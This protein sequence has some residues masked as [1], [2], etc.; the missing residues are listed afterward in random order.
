MVQFLSNWVTVVSVAFILCLSMSIFSPLINNTFSDLVDQAIYN[1]QSTSGNNGNMDSYYA[2][3]SSSK[4]L[5]VTIF[6]VSPYF[7]SITLLVW[8]VLSSLRKEDSDYY[9]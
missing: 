9:V 3:L 5:I 1:G 8:A 6:N 2:S 4:H 7:I